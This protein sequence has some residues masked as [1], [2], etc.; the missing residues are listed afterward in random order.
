MKK[1]NL[2]KSYLI[3]S[4]DSAVEIKTQDI[5][6]ESIS[7]FSDYYAAT[8]NYEKAYEYLMRF[9]QLRDSIVIQSSHNI[10]EMQMRY[11]KGKQEKEKQ[12]LRDKI[13]IQGLELERNRLVRWLT[14][15]SLTLFTLISF[16][17]YSRF[18]VKK[19]ANI[20]LESKIEQAMKDQ[21]EQQ[22]I[23]F[24]QASLSSLG[25]L[26]ASMA[27][28]INQ[29][30]QDLKLCAEYVELYVRE[31]GTPDTSLLNSIVDI[32]QDIERIKQIVDHVRIFSSQQKNHVDK[33]FTVN[34]VVD[35]ALSM[36]GK[37]CTK[38]GIAVHLDLKKNT[39]R[40]KGNP[41][42][43]EQVLI[44]I[45][46]NAKDALLAKDN[47]IRESFDKKITILAYKKENNIIIEIIDNG[48]GIKPELKD[49]IFKSFY[50]TKELGEG[51]G[52]GLSIVQGII[53]EFKGDISIN[54]EYLKGTTVEIRLPK[55]V[56]N[57]E[58]KNKQLNLK[59]VKS[60]TN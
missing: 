23:I 8:N 27:H 28:E 25:E 15:L 1:F 3:E 16:W 42:K 36:I 11:E 10:A 57:L 52:L 32:Y 51:T 29:P 55:Y 18:Q 31:S 17:G 33:L 48:I 34:T 58:S 40:V 49:S 38:H 6:L 46:S 5:L 41:F 30:L 47:K 20:I 43:L 50:T 13:H 37:Q 44:N 24:H 9:T 21:E 54:S 12:I 59:T 56:R 35:D 60:K 39:G 4:R 2:A 19:R 14:A 22:K 26:A 53:K 45:L 7:A